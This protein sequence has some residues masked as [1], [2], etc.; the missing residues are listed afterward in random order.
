MAE[1]T[2]AVKIEDVE[3]DIFEKGL[4]LVPVQ[5]ETN[6]SI[7]TLKKS[8]E[9]VMYEKFETKYGGPVRTY[10]RFLSARDWDLSKAEKMLR[11][12]ISFR[13]E[14]KLDDDKSSEE[15]DHLDKC[16]QQVQ[17]IWILRPWGFSVEKHVLIY[18][19]VSK[20]KLKEFLSIPEENI[21]DFYLNWVNRIFDMQNYGNAEKDATDKEW[22]GNVQVV[23]LK[24]I[25]MGQLHISGL[26]LLNRVLKIAQGLA[27]ENLTK[28]YIINAPWYFQ[29]AWGIIKKGLNKGIIEKVRVTSGDCKDELVSYFGSEEGY[30]DFMNSV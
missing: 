26:R 5:P 25:S 3:S 19:R 20:L 1:D 9:D 16:M 2:V 18:V 13:K 17:P 11:E 23:N 4:V 24:G 14:K 28:S 15:L 7:E 8:V 6:N 30:N 10:E 22:K 27:P 12:C 21:K 29:G